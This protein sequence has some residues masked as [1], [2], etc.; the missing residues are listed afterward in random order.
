[1]GCAWQLQ[2]V[3]HEGLERLSPAVNK[4]VAESAVNG[5]ISSKKA[6]ESAINGVISSKKAAEFA[7]YSKTISKAKQNAAKVQ[8]SRGSAA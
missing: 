5:V 1:M 2:E 4:K 7:E 6:A 8:F 3:L